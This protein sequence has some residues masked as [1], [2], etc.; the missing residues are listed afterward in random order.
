MK[1][2][3]VEQ[4]VSG[5]D[6]AQFRSYLK[7]E[8]ARVWELTQADVIREVYFRRDRHDAV[9]V[10]ECDDLAAAEAVLQT[11]P[12]VEHGLIRFEVIPLMPYSGFER[13]FE[14]TT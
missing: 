14:Q 2:L 9:L 10:L 1:I 7:A 11:L 8:A 5:I 3:A 12:L 6:P 4:E 13:L